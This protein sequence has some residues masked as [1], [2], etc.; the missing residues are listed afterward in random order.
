MSTRNE[1]NH[2]DSDSDLEEMVHHMIIC[3]HIYEY[4]QSYVDRTP[5]HN[6]VLSGHEY[7]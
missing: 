3:I 4:W 2:S 7:I 6:S 1:D 5:C